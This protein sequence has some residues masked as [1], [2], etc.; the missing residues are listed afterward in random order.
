MRSRFQNPE[1][2]NRVLSVD[3]IIA[4]TMIESWFFYD[5]EGI[6]KFLRVPRARRNPKKYKPPE[7]FTHIDLST[8]FKQNGK[9]YIKGERCA[10]FINALDL[11]KIYLNCQELKSGLD[12]INRRFNL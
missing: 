7:K 9:S 2:G 6:Y 4:T 11:K 1:F 10:G 8:L 5:I 3:T 12:K